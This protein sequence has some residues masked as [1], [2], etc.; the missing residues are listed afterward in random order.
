MLG[1]LG[2]IVQDIV[3]WQ[4][5]PMRHAS[6]TSARIYH[7]RGG[8]A[9]N[10]A[11]FAAP[12]YPTRFLG[13]AGADPAGDALQQ[14]LQSHGVDVRLQRRD[15]TG[16]IVVLVDPEGERS[17][18][19]SRGASACL[20]VVAD[21][22]LQGVE[23]LHCPAY[24]FQGGSTESSAL[25]AIARLQ[26]RGGLISMDAS[27]TGLIQAVGV[28]EFMD[29]LVSIGPD[30]LSADRNECNLLGLCEDGRPGKNLDRLPQ[31]TVLAHA[32]AEPTRILQAGEELAVVAVPPVDEIC[33]VTGAGDAFVAGFLAHWLGHRGQIVDACKAGHALASR[34]LG[35]HGAR[36]DDG[37]EA[38]D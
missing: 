4:D 7:Q 29:R 1:V 14:E 38:I 27:S 5:E 10:V 23:L 9:A 12:Y 33:D 3:V 31:T 21:D 17:M 25:D 32:G 22:D 13:C 16:T 2:D 8:S 15:N 26:T 24:A 30:F 34:V 36:V 19:P 20:E 11:A 37:A 35:C 28:D 18:F 6:D